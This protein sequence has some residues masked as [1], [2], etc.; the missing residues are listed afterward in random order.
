[1][2]QV[3]NVLR[4]FNHL[5]LANEAEVAPSAPQDRGDPLHKRSLLLTDARSWS[6]G[7]RPAS[8]LSWLF[9][10]LHLRKPPGLAAN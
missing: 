6:A 1:M 7:G 5:A 4:H 3:E 9:G 8:R 2:W 10:E